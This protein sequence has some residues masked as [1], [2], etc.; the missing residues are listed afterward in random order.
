MWCLPP[1]V[2]GQ[3][4]GV[5]VQVFVMIPALTRRW[6][7][8]SPPPPCDHDRRQSSSIK[9]ADPSHCAALAVGGVG[10][11]PSMSSHTGDE[12]SGCHHHPGGAPPP[13]AALFV[14]MVT[15]LWR[16]W[17]RR[18]GGDG[19]GSD[20]APP[21]VVL[22]LLHLLPPPPLLFSAPRFASRRRP[23]SSPATS[24]PW[25]GASEPSCSGRVCEGQRLN[26]SMAGLINGCYSG[27]RGNIQ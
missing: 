10:A 8:W 22:L 2:Q 24:P 7:P 19:G 9:G 21:P 1:R 15:M 14:L 27:V 13:R 6:S 25:K 5:C 16:R 26:I 11:A 3:V 17:L 4:S 23:L 20:A 12:S 18:G